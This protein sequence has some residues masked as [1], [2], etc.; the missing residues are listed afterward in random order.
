LSELLELEPWKLSDEVDF[1]VLPAQAVVT[2]KPK[3]SKRATI[4]ESGRSDLFGVSRWLLIVCFV[5]IALTV[6]V[7]IWSEELAGGDES[8]A[9]VAASVDIGDQDIMKYIRSPR[10][11]QEILYAVTEPSFGALSEAEQKELLG[12]I[13]E[14]AN[15]RN[16]SKVSLV[17][18]SGK[19]VAFASKDRLEL[20][21]H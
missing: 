1:T 8:V 20:V 5:C 16:L 13:R 6:A 11:T 10:A 4:Y 3:T 19:T 21:T 18:S 2:T 17:N 14:I 15:S 7:Y 12:K 9:S